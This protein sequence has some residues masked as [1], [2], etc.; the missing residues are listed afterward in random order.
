MASLWTEREGIPSSLPIGMQPDHPGGVGAGGVQPAV[1][2]ACSRAA[3]LSG[4]NG[5]RR[6]TSNCS[7]QLALPMKNLPDRGG[8]GFGNDEHV[9]EDETIPA[10]EQASDLSGLL[11]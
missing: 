8:I 10:A 4:I 9:P 11:F 3:L 6:R 1:V 5:N 2:R 7:R